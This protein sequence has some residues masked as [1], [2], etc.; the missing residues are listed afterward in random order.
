MNSSFN[1]IVVTDRQSFIK[2]LDL[3]LEDLQ[4]NPES[5]KNDTLLRFLQGLCTYSEDIQGFYDNM[6][7]D[8]NADKPDWSTFADIFR[9][10]R[11]YE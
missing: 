8:V 6:K 1:N 4:N 5:W 9:G 3:L 10:A 2:F 7:L 11:I